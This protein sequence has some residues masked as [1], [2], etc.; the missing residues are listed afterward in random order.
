MCQPH[1]LFS[2]N[3]FT[4]HFGYSVI[5]M[6]HTCKMSTLFQLLTLG[7]YGEMHGLTYTV[8]IHS[9]RAYQFN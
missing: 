2:I 1:L 9:C 8:D 4:H 3:L 6:P 5:L 7:S